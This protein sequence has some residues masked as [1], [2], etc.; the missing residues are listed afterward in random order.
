MQ[1][2]ISCK[3]FGLPSAGIHCWVYIIIVAADVGCGLKHHSSQRKMKVYLLHHA[4]KGK[5]V[6]I[7]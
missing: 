1:L 3:H 2:L 7:V 5:G 6:A 4:A